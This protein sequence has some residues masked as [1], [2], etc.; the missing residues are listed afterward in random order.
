MYALGSKRPK[1][2]RKIQRVLTYSNKSKSTLTYRILNVSNNKHFKSSQSRRKQVFPSFR[3]WGKQLFL[4]R[5]IFFYQILK[6]T[7]YLHSKNY[8]SQSLPKQNCYLECFNIFLLAK[9]GNDTWS[10]NFVFLRRYLETLQTNKYNTI[11]TTNTINNN[12]NYKSLIL[13]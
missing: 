9:L 6:K 12:D 7:E 10:C 8:R 5:C 1:V 2:I 3:K 13:F 4:F 11:K